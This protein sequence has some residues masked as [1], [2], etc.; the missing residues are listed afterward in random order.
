MARTEQERQTTKHGKG[1]AEQ[2]RQTTKHGTIVAPSVP[3]EHLTG[4]TFLR[5]LY[6]YNA[7]TNGT[8]FE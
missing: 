8:T 2:G 6:V 5:P 3:P 4:Q 7:P 1:R